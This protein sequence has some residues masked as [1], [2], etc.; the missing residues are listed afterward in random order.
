MKD[1]FAGFSEMLSVR[2]KLGKSGAKQMAF[3]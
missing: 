2:L 3:I 1:G